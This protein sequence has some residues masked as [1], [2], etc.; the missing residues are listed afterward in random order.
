MKCVFLQV[1]LPTGTV[2]IVTA[3]TQ[4]ELGLEIRPSVLDMNQTQGDKARTHAR[5]HTQTNELYSK[6]VPT[7]CNIKMIVNCIATF[8]V[9]VISF[10]EFTSFYF[11]HFFIF[12]K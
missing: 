12:R 3:G 11:S 2:A 7:A 9:T 6:A 5:T 4:T 1:L 10:K 8:K